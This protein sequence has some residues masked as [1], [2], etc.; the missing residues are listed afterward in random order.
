MLSNEKTGFKELL[1]STLSVY[2]KTPDPATIGIWWNALVNHEFHNVKNAFSGH[3]RRS[4]FAPRP[5]DILEL[6]DSANPDGHLGADEAWAMMP[7]DDETASVVMTEEMSEALSI[8]SIAASISA[9]L[10]GLPNNS[11]SDNGIM[12]LFHPVQSALYSPRQ[13]QADKIFQHP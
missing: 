4:K 8:E 12:D 7:Y 2:E 13:S 10:N 11:D 5:A 3:I 6:L 1:T 9:S